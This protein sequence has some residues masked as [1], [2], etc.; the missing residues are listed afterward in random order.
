M[1]AD[2]SG[3]GPR[4]PDSPSGSGGPCGQQ[5]VTVPVETGS[6]VQVLVPPSPSTLPELPELPV[7]S[8]R[9]PRTVRGLPVPTH[10]RLVRP[11]GRAC[12]PRPRDQQPG[13]FD[14]S[15]EEGPVRSPLSPG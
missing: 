14:R 12:R 3:R 15:A 10:A 4:Q 6:M 1:Y 5:L 11:T 8:P 7:F 9:T 13:V 2:N